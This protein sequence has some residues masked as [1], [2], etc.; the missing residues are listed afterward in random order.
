MISPDEKLSQSARAFDDL[1][2]TG[3]IADDV[4]QVYD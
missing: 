2:G 4:A 1:I 3:A